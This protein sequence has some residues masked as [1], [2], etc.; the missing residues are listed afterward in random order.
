M[1]SGSPRR[2]RGG[3]TCMVESGP[4]RTRPREVR[5]TAC[6]RQTDESPFP[7]SH[8]RSL[9]SGSPQTWTSATD[10]ARF[11]TSGSSIG[12]NMDAE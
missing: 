10:S 5:S 1:S 6:L 9:G 4:A 7:G 2:L 11:A 3:A 12:T 8:E